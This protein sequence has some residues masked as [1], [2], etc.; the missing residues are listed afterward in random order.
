M[1]KLTLLIYLL[2]FDIREQGYSAGT[3]LHIRNK[4]LV[5]IYYFPY[6]F[7]NAMH[8][9]LTKAEDQFGEQTIIIL[10]VS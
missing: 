8:Q 7:D 9:G 1:K 6:V 4:K 10:S 5:I 3:G 2:F